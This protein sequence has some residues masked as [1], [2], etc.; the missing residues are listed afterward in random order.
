MPNITIL[1]PDIDLD[2]FWS[3]LATATHRLLL[4]DYDGTLAPF[5]KERNQAI[6]Y[7]GVRELLQNMIEA[8]HSR[9]VIISGRA[10]KDLVPLLGLENHPEIWGS[11]GLEH[12][13]ADGSYEVTELDSAAQNTLRQA[14]AWIREAGLQEQSERKPGSVA[15][16]WR[17]MPETEQQRLKTEFCEKWTAAA[18]AAGLALKEFDGGIELQA[19]VKNKGDAV[20]AILT[21]TKEK[22]TAAVYL[23]DDFTDED[24]FKALKGRGLSVLVRKEFRQTAADIWLQPPKELLKFLQRWHETATN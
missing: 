11:H 9:I 1:N 15:L 24:A 22:E 14:E 7:P 2:F 13:T 21:E 20:N 12:L 10:T 5:S 18:E 6:P 19:T 16:H 23:G 17:G 8:Q 4:L 3:R